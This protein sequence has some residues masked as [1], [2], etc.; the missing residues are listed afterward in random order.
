MSRSRER[1]RKGIRGPLCG[2]AASCGLRGTAGQAGVLRPWP[3]GCKVHV[4][5]D[6]ARG[7]A[8]SVVVTAASVRCYAGACAARGQETEVFADAGYQGADKRDQVKQRHPN[9]NWHIAMRPSKCQQLDTTRP[10]GVILD[11]IET[12]K[13]RICSRGEHIFGVVKGVFC[14]TKDCGRGLRENA[15]QITALWMLANLWMVR[16]HLMQPTTG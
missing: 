14:Y 1:R 10:L 4:G 11:R 15:A 16:W 13:A 12:V 6:A 5:T 9:V 8:P 7:L 3:S 2:F